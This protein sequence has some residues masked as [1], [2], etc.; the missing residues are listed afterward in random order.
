MVVM[1]VLDIPAV[2]RWR[3]LVADPTLVE[4]HL[5]VRLTSPEAEL[6]DV[7]ADQLVAALDDAP[8]PDPLP[9]GDGRRELAAL[10]SGFVAGLREARQA[11]GVP[12]GRADVLEVVAGLLAAGKALQALDTHLGRILIGAGMAAA[13]GL[14]AGAGLH[15]VLAAASA[16]FTAG[17]YQAPERHRRLFSLIAHI[18][19][20]FSAAT[21]PHRTGPVTASCGARPGEHSGEPFAAEI[22]FTV[23]ASQ[24]LSDELRRDLRSLADEVTVWSTGERHQFHVHATDPGEVVTTAFASVTLFDLRIGR[25]GSIGSQGGSQ[26]SPAQEDEA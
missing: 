25:R 24:Q 6:L 13:D 17:W 14:V 10:L 3:S 2:R 22:T 5:R 18:L 9:G 4:P 19:A 1:T 26:D 21:G 23:I 11:D 15:H 12:A 16:T 7:A 20:A 8:A